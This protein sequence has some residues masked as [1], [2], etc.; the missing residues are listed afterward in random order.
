MTRKTESLAYPTNPLAAMR[1]LQELDA[2]QGNTIHATSSV[3]SSEV[4]QKPSSEHS[5]AR[6]SVDGSAEARAE[7][8]QP[9]QKRSS[10]ARAAETDT[11]EASSNAIA[12][13]VWSMLQKPYTADLRKGPFTVSTVKIPTEVWERLGWVSNLTGQRKQE[14]ITEALKSH[15][16]KVLKAWK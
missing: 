12:D 8:R 2:A 13:A 7:T 10:R 3:D 4:A 1:D 5:S 11:G 9:T 15:F 6:N 14:I 16:E